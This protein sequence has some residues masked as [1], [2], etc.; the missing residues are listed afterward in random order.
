MAGGDVLDERFSC[1]EGRRPRLLSPP[2]PMLAQAGIGGFTA[3]CRHVPR[4]NQAGFL[5]ACA[6]V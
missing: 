4:R 6:T 3:V 1:R 5:Q 2:A